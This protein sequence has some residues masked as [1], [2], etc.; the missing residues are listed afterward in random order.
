MRLVYARVT[1]GT[2]DPREAATLNSI[3]NDVAFALSNL[4][5]VYADDA[6]SACRSR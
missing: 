6:Q 1:G 4:V 2:P 5:P 3:L